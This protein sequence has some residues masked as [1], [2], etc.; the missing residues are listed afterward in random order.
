MKNLF[1][2][3]IYS[4]P[5]IGLDQ[6]TKFYAIEGKLSGEIVPHILDFSLKDD[7]IYYFR[8]QAGEQT[9]SGKMVKVK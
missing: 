2:I 5:L 9:A 4:L 8:L 3:I 1:K 7:G 6:L